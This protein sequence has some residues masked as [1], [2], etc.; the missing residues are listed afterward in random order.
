MIWQLDNVYGLL[1]IFV[2]TEMLFI[3]VPMLG[4]SAIPVQV[5]VLLGMIV[6]AILLPVS[7]TT[8][9][10]GLDASSLL[11][12]MLYE[13]LLGLTMGLAM[14]GVISCISFGA[15]TITNEI[16]L[17]RAETFD[18]S[19]AD[20][21]SGGGINTLLFY[22][23]MTIF[24]ALGLHRQVILALAESFRALPAGCM[25]TRGLSL[26]TVL[27]VTLQIFVV[28]ILMS[29]PFLAVNFLINTTFSLLG[30]VA[31]KMN[32]FVISFAVRIVVGLAVLVTTATL[33]AHYMEAELSQVPGRM[34]DLILGR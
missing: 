27:R 24:L 18:P 7:P 5:R 2:R 1:L 26:D 13:A 31:P 28:G 12:A 8:P 11:V 3:S 22:L 21:G 9:L 33:L 17:I 30:K 25:D 19:S 29:A 4:G 6:S 20:T 14:N 23:G 15:D 16:G 32:V 34:L 10:V